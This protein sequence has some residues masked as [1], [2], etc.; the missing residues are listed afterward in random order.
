MSTLGLIGC[1]LLGG[2]VALALKS[3]NCFERVL[4][5]DVNQTNLDSALTRGVIDGVLV[6]TTAADALCVAVPTAAIADVL[7]EAFHSGVGQHIPTFDVGSVK[8]SIL[9]SLTHP[10]PNFVPCHPI[11]G[12]H[13]SGP[14]VADVELFRNSTCIMTPASETSERHIQ[15]VE[16]LWHAMG[17]TVV[18]MSSEQHDR[19]LALTSHLPHLLSVAI[20]KQVF[21]TDGVSD[22]LGNG[23][24]DFSRI[25][26]GDAKVW[27]DIFTEN[28]DELRIHFSEFVSIVE[29]LLHQ[30]T[31]QPVQ[32]EAQLSVVSNKRKSFDDL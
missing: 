30:A 17:A 2:S 6:D 15:Y 24:R 25:A 29:S 5:K 32:L 7:N 4:G 10:L 21:Q 23:F 11:A 12:S 27:R 31:E 9:R 1:G 3:S 16:E 26:A 20:V 22:Y 14:E 13:E 18:K 28:S 19:I 8:G